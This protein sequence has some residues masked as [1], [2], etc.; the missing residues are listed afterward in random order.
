MSRNVDAALVALFIAV[1]LAVAL[2]GVMAIRKALADP[3][4]SA[5]KVGVEAVAGA[6]HA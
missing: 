3:K 6:S 2:S 1:L 4:V 5:V